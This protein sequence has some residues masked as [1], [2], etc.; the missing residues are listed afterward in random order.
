MTCLNTLSSYSSKSVFKAKTRAQPCSNLRS[1]LLDRRKLAA[2]PGAGETPAPPHRGVRDSQNLGHLA[3]IQTGK[4][5][6]FHHARRL[7][8]HT[9]QPI[10][11][12]IQLVDISFR[13]RCRVAVFFERYFQPQAALGR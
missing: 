2:Q 9:L 6:E 13:Y 12:L 4:K 7:R 11:H 8:V 10:K 3:I 5:L 1:N